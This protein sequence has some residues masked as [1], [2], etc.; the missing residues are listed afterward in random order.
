MA[1]DDTRLTS[2]T[3]PAARHG[4]QWAVFAA[5]V[6][7]LVVTGLLSSGRL[8]AIAER[9]TFGPGRDRMLSLAQDVDGLAHRVGLD[10]PAALVDVVV[11]PRDA[12]PS[13][14]LPNTAPLAEASAE[15]NPTVAPTAAS[16]PTATS[17]P[18]PTVTT[19]PSA[20]P[21]SP[22]TPTAA[23]AVGVAGTP[24]SEAATATPEQPLPSSTPPPST[25]TASPAPTPDDTTP[26]QRPAAPTAAPTAIVAQPRRPAGL[27][28][29]TTDN[30]LRVLTGGDSFAQPLGYDLNGYAAKYKLI[31]TQLD[32]KISTGLARPDFF[33]WPA[34]LRAIMAQKPAPEVVV[35]VVGGNDTQNMWDE[36]RVYV[37]G[38]EAWQAEYGRRAAEV[39]DIVG[40]GGARLYWVGMPIMRDEERNRI[41]DGMN[42]AVVAQMEQR[43]WVRYVDLWALFQDRDGHF[44]TYLP[45]ETGE[46]IPVRQNDGVHLTWQ[47][48]TWVSALVYRALERDYAF[49]LPP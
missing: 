27:R 34:R 18:A 19:A 11:G 38:T 3:S 16:L 15:S 21:T 2:D 24:T 47:G 33:D 35:L 9:M 40:Q 17:S 43:P 39:M 10:R 41:V 37:R 31:T 8:V 44:A 28:A 25:T 13:F 7:C 30:P 49:P 48:N 32:F 29:V 5:L 20:T 42:Q 26:G 14:A 46:M 1:P 4:S 45:D 36:Q 6:V 12:L 23:E 22:A